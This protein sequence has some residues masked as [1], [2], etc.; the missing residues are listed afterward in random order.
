M[1]PK[2]FLPVAKNTEPPKAQYLCAQ[3]TN[4]RS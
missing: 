2:T 1:D 3:R 4:A